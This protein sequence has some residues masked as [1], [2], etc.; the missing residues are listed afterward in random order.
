M[1]LF[2]QKNDVEGEKCACLRRRFN[3]LANSFDPSDANISRLSDALCFTVWCALSLHVSAM[4]GVS[5]LSKLPPAALSLFPCC[6]LPRFLSI[7]LSLACPNILK[8]IKR[9][10]HSDMLRAWLFY[11]ACR[12]SNQ[13]KCLSVFGFVFTKNGVWTISILI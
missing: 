2:A 12:S 13:K 6:Q 8:L 1:R 9:L 5:I 3:F 10:N 7:Y 4:P 11:E